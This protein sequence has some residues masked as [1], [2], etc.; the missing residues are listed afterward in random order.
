MQAMAE[1]LENEW[2]ENEINVPQFRHFEKRQGGEL[3]GQDWKTKGKLFQ[4]CHLLHF[5]NGSFIFTNRR[6]MA[7]AC[8]IIHST[9]AR[10]GL[11]MH[12]N[13]ET[14]NHSRLPPS[15]APKMPKTTRRHS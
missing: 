8:R 4:L 3:L 7:R 9:M 2:R 1:V 5:Y 15:I 14:A 12:V 13:T 10:F 11:I 6:D